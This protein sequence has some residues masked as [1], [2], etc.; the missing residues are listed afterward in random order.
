[1]RLFLTYGV[2]GYYV[3]AGDTSRTGVTGDYDIV[4]FSLTGEGS[5]TLVATTPTLPLSGGAEAKILGLQWYAMQVEVE[6]PTAVTY[7]N[8]TY[9]S[10]KTVVLKA[11]D[12]TAYAQ[13]LGQWTVGEETW[14]VSQQLAGYAY[15]VTGVRGTTYPFTALY[16]AASNSFQLYEQEGVQ[17]LEV[18]DGTAEAP[19]YVEYAVAL[20]GNFTYGGKNYRWSQ[21]A[22]VATAQLEA[23][24]ATLT[25][26]N[27]S[28]TYG[29]YN[30]FTLYRV[31][32]ADGKYYTL[33]SKFALP[34]SISAASA[35]A[36]A[37]NAAPRAFMPPVSEI[38]IDP[39]S[40]S[41]S[42]VELSAKA[43]YTAVPM[44]F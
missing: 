2:R 19:N 20:S 40:E 26:C 11:T 6:K 44:A 16:D 15:T 29:D 4:S 9:L 31:S 3:K 10:D 7:A 35:S 24:A 13:W 5:G 36:P 17:K 43:P 41:S 28:A 22:L 32:S 34:A 42:S 30:G 23:G 38:G 12:Q 27:V 21:G 39:V 37:V 1:M 14:T 8:Y 33:A 18:N 25:P